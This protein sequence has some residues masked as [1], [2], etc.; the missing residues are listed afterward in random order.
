MY[1]PDASGGYNKL[2]LLSSVTTKL[3]L[4]QITDFL[5]IMHL[6]SHYFMQVI[7]H[8]K[9]SGSIVMETPLVLDVVG[10][11]DL[12]GWLYD[13]IG[14]FQNICKSINSINISDL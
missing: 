14:R 11:S 6:I 2:T 7:S 3:L 10:T 12:E 8:F 1:P 5:C 9:P 4:I 13:E